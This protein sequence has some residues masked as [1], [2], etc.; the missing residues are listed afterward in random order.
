MLEQGNVPFGGSTEAFA[1][2]VDRNLA[3]STR[4]VE[5]AKAAGAKFE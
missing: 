3:I 1:A 5:A 4:L 2:E